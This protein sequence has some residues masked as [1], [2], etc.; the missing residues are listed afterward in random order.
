MGEKF[1]LR[2]RYFFLRLT[3]TFLGLIMQGQGF[4]FD[5]NILALM[6]VV[7]SFHILVP[8]ID[9]PRSGDGE[10][11][12]EGRLGKFTNASRHISEQEQV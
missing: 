8:V 1:L 6:S 5:S 3:T 7:F 10:D 4:C 9:R 12:R 2:L 11:G